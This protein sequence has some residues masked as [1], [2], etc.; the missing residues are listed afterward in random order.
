MT[1]TIGGPPRGGKTTL[2]LER[3]AAV[4][5]ATLLAPDES[6]AAELR[7]RAPGAAVRSLEALALDVLRAGG[8]EFVEIDDVDAFAS[9]RECARP[10]LQMEWTELIEAEIDPEVPGLRFPD[11]FLAAAF[12]LIQKLRDA[13]IAPAAFLESALKGAA[14]FY[15]TPPN[16]AQPE[17]LAYTKDVYRD[18]LHVN[19][20][21]LQRQYRHEID[22]AKI[23]AKLYETYAECAKATAHLTPR[24]T[25]L[26]A[27]N[28]LRAQPRI[29]ETLR[30]ELG[31][32]FVDDAQELT[33]AQIAL[34][35]A[36]CGDDLT[37]VTL[38]GDASAAFSAFRGA[39]A[40]RALSF[41]GDRTVLHAPPSGAALRLF[42]ASTRRAE[43]GFIAEH[44]A[45][46]AAEG[47]DPASIAILSRSVAD[48]RPFVD[49]LIARNVP[50]TVVGD[51]NL[52]AEP[53]ALDAL[54]PLWFLCDP[55]R[56]DWLLRLLS[57]PA[58]ALSDA[59]LQTLCAEPPDA[60]LVLF[61]EN[62]APRPS[63][64]WDP[65][66]D[67]RLGWNV[68]RGDQ[69]AFLSPL[70]L[71]R[72]RRL[73]VL[74]SR[75][76]PMLA[77]GDLGTIAQTVWRDVLARRG[78]PG[79]AAAA[80]QQHVLRRLLDR[81]RT[82]ESASPARAMREFLEHAQER[83]DSEFTACETAA[84]P[85]AVL[86]ASIDVVR[87]RSFEHVAVPGARAGSFPRWYVP[88]SFL[89]SPRLGMIAKE[90]V[91]EARASR[92]AKFTYYMYA[93]KARER[94]NQE[95]R[96]AFEYALSRANRTLLVTAS[97]RPTRGITAPEFLHEL[98]AARL[99]HA[100]DLSD[101]WRPERPVSA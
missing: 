88:D 79:G 72:L 5:Q 70:A 73:R 4:A 95:E 15:A 90:N 68:V 60:Q 9:F 22:L 81:M 87:G 83:M 63:G 64:R 13:G 24:D 55:F 96:R 101:R 69:D 48:A 92:T 61:G 85:N 71:E 97:E 21:E 36:L 58:L 51:L 8:R 75:W 62:A 7:R 98:Q 37:G 77:H 42:R 31:E 38:A 27:A 82:F 34:L 41:P 76:E 29:A 86:V 28:V 40:D 18:S 67:L 2:L 44:V 14:H 39:R 17:L 91:G 50:V 100:V 78:A 56:H 10:L 19:V 93:S 59:A 84:A 49:A 35:Q 26:E 16:L 23:I 53:E 52:F 1:S 25:T 74:R 32:L 99:P 46:L 80:Y 12:R 20:A 94:Y 11:R 47:A 30:R 43:I 33:P 45:R 89:Y 66:R 65:R 57:G 54:A 6:A 3:A